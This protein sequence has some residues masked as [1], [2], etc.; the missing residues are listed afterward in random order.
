MRSLSAAEQ[1]LRSLGVEEPCEIDLNAIAWH[2]GVVE[3]R[4]RDLCGCEARIVGHGKNAI[5]SVRRSGNPQR[6][7]FSIC[8]ELGH[9]H[10]HRG[11]T[12]YCTATDIRE[13]EVVAAKEKVANSFASDLLLPPYIFLPIASDYRSLNVLAIQEIASVFDASWSATAMKVVRLGL[14]PMVIVCHGPSG[15]KWH[16]PAPG[17]PSC[18]QPR[19]DL[20]RSSPAFDMLYSG[21][22]EQRAPKRVGAHVWF[23]RRD[24]ERFEVSEESLKVAADEVWTLITLWDRRMLDERE[25]SGRWR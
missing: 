25:L 14:A 3:I 20:D 21:L 1:L 12:L 17:I 8:H 22:R 15:K 23:G 2:L 5:I 16:M 4:E 19:T 7:R 11:Q 24:A 6:K 18:W 9:W 13:R 10:H